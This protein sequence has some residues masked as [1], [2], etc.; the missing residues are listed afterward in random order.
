MLWR[1][2]ESWARARQNTPSDIYSFGIMA[3]YV[4][5]NEMVFVGETEELEAD[6]AWRHVLRKH[7]S[8]F[9]DDDGFKGLLWH[10]GQDN[11]FFERLIELAG[12]FDTENTRQPFEDWEYVDEGFRDLIGK[13][14]NLNP[15]KRITAKEALEHPWWSNGGD[16]VEKK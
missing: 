15:E 2:P 12:S 13:M 3:I 7:I 4:M 9:A 14:V 11:P 5:I 10:I 8:Y 16:L 1:S 6:D